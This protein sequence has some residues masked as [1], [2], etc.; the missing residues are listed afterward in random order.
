[1]SR[2]TCSCGSLTAL[3]TV[4]ALS[5]GAAQ[6]EPVFDVPAPAQSQVGPQYTLTE[7]NDANENLEFDPRL[8][9]QV[10]NYAGHEAPAR[11]LL[12]VNHVP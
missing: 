2:K 7:Q 9:R 6:A 12:H 3:I 8:Q 5:C 1:M 10:V 11:A 4:A